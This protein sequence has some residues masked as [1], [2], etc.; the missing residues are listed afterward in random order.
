[1]QGYNQGDSDYTLFTK[2]SK[3]RKIVVLIVY[4]DDIALSGDDTDEIIQLKKKMG[5]EFEIME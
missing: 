3:T 1:M 2:V 5:F 4:L